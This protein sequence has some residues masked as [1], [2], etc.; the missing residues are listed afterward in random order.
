MHEILNVVALS[1]NVALYPAY[2]DFW[3]YCIKVKYILQ[4]HLYSMLNAREGIW[5]DDI[6]TFSI[7]KYKVKF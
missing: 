3:D 2:E 4:K 1:A 7:V 5:I 6:V